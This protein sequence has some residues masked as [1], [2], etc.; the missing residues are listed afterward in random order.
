MSKV[1][2]ES[3]KEPGIRDAID[4][5]ER[6]YGIPAEHI[7][8]VSVDGEVGHPVTVSVTLFWQDEPGFT[9][10]PAVLCVKC[11]HQAHLHWDQGRPNAEPRCIGTG[12]G[13]ACDCSRSC[14][15]VNQLNG[16]DLDANG[17]LIETGK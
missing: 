15:L 6:K 3:G 16:G 14:Q 17:C 4:Y 1:A 11:N 10:E 9:A 13:L 12:P 2:C 7:R 5:L 8:A